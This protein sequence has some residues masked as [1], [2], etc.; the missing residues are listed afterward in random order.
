MNQVPQPFSIGHYDTLL[1]IM[2][3]MFVLRPK[4][5]SQT[6]HKEALSNFE[7]ISISKL[8]VS[9]NTNTTMLKYIPPPPT[10]QQ[11]QHKNKTKQNDR[12]TAS[13]S[14]YHIRIIP[15]ST[16]IGQSLTHNHYSKKTKLFSI[17]G[18]LKKWHALYKTKGARDSVRAY[19]P[20]FCFNYLVMI[21][22]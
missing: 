18:L 4:Y 13:T 11:H 8:F 10:K 22:I 5:V 2:R 19:V 16:W 12:D 17:I 6:S 3:K 20:D 7:S 9:Y 21:D 15:Y 1:Q 14:S